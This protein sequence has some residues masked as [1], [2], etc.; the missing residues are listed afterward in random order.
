MKNEKEK[1]KKK[2]D[3]PTMTYSGEVYC[4]EL[5]CEPKICQFPNHRLKTNI[6]MKKDIVWLKISGKGTNMKREGESERE[7][8]REEERKEER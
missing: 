6:R 1:K 8:E 2:M 7:K 3:E 4:V 5:L